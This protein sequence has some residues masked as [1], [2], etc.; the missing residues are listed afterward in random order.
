MSEEQWLDTIKRMQEK[1]P[2]LIPD[3]KVN[4]LAAYFHRRELT[5]AQI[6]SGKCQLCHHLESGKAP[7]PGSTQQMDGLITLATSEFGNSLQITDINNLR[8]L[9]V[10][11]QKRSME[12]YEHKC[13]TCH[14]GKLPTKRQPGQE[15]PDGP[16][17]ADWIAF[18]AALQGEELSKEI[19]NTISS[20]IDFHIS[21]H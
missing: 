17:R 19:Q 12:L 14:P 4:L 21:R 2:E 3:E 11:R 20:Q 8:S 13:E 16:S 5:M 1:A 7:P 10:Q 9:H 18:I 6:F 15:K